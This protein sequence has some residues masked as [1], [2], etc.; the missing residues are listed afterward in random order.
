MSV[1]IRTEAAEFP[2]KEY[3]NKIFVAVW[4][5]KKLTP[6]QKR[7]LRPGDHLVRKIHTIREI[8]QLIKKINSFL[9]LNGFC[10]LQPKVLSNNMSSL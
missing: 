6:R 7:Q 3:I 2:E 10:T 8:C 1:E 5:G 4:K 9:S